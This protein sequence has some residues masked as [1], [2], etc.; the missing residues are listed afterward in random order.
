MTRHRLLTVFVTAVVFSSLVGCSLLKKKKPAD[1]DPSLVPDAATVSVTG[2]GAKNEASVL[3][4]ADETAL[5]NEP[6][7]IAK[8][9]AVA[10]N[11]PGN[12]PQVAFLPKGTPVAKLA[13]RFSTA[14][15]I[16]FDDPSSND[17]TKLIGWVT[18]SVFDVAA[19]PPVKPIVVPPKKDA[20]PPPT[21]TVVDAGGGGGG[22]AT[23]TDAGGG[24]GNA[25]IPQPAKGVQ[26]VAPINGKC[27]DNWVVTEG[28]C[29][30]KCTADKD[31]DRSTIK[32]VSRGGQKVCSSG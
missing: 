21:P 16:M 9:G 14:I 26:A 27:P 28:M 32:C 20:G 23:V 25:S 10:R 8:D 17:G 31:C 13:R 4:Y 11:F 5:S 6:A 18:P 30:K 22:N 2:I 15:L 3:R 12:G 29:R 24:G 19:P 7:V 1:E